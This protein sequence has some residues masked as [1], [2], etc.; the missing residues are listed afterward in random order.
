MSLRNRRAWYFGGVHLYG[1]GGHRRCC[2]AQDRPIERGNDYTEGEDSP[3][4]KQVSVSSREDERVVAVNE[5]TRPVC[6]APLFC[7]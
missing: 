1:R 6:P 7:Q 4:G 3:C 2:D 5:R